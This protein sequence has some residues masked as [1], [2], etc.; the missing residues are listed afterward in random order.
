MILISQKTT[1]QS[2]KLGLARK[3]LKKAASEYSSIPKRKFSIR[4]TTTEFTGT[5]G[6]HK[7]TESKFKV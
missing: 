2:Q 5:A 4:E 6:Y 7:Y 1:N 3:G